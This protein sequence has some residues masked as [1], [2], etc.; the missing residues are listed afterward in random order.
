MD[1]QGGG[2]DLSVR[3]SL[4]IDF[5]DEGLQLLHSQRS[6]LVEKGQF[7]KKEEGYGKERQELPILLRF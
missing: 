1:D 6:E 2:G 5:D 4:D 3:V 7:E